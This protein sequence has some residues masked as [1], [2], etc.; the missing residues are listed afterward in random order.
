MFKVC[1]AFL[2]VKTNIIKANKKIQKMFKV[3]SCLL[4]CGIVKIK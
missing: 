1:S 4:A 2:L 3:C